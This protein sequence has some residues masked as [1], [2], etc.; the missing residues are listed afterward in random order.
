VRL[1]FDRLT[2]KGVRLAHS[3]LGRPLLGVKTGCNEAFAVVP[4]P[5]WREAHRDG[6]EAW[7][8]RA[9]ARDEMMELDLLRPMLRGE[10]VRAWRADATDGAIVW[11]HGADGGVLD[12]LPPLAEA[13]LTPWRR[14]LEARSDAARSRR[15]WALF[16]TESASHR[17]PRV[18][19]SDIS[20]VPR[21][22]VLEAGDTT[23]A[24]NS[25]YVLPLQTIDEAHAFAALLN[26]APVSAWLCALAEPARGGYRRFLGWTLARLPIPAKWDRAVTLLAPIGRRACE[27]HAPDAHLLASAVARAYGVRLSTLEP[28]LTWC[29]R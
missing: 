1:A 18:V 28:L 22:C 7:S 15:W 13:W 5:G 27:G 8:V 19:W 20:R 9:D 6:T 12:Q 25:C 29:L 3:S 14:R 26:S 21:A 24:L 17:L 4:R 10:D 11:T 16:R 2:A 23:I